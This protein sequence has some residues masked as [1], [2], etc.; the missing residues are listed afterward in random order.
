MLIPYKKK[1]LAIAV[2]NC[3]IILKMGI[4]YYL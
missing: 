4:F 3:E 2:D 1:K